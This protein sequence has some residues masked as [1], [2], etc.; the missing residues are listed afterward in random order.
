MSK[1]VPE[2]IFEDLQYNPSRPNWLP[3]ENV[4]LSFLDR[5]GD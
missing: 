3:V 2:A 4:L 1:N 5:E